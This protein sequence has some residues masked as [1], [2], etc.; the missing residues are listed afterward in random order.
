MT[1]RSINILQTSY[2]AIFLPIL[3]ESQS[4]LNFAPNFSNEWIKETIGMKNDNKNWLK[5]ILRNVG[6]TNVAHVHQLNFT[7][8][9][10]VTENG[11]LT[12]LGRGLFIGLMIV[13]VVYC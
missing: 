12:G 5:Y 4:E 13:F 8:L 11:R 1:Q 10:L 9:L 2:I 7:E 3:N 6:C